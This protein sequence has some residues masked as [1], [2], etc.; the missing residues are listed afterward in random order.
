MTRIIVRINLS[1]GCYY[2]CSSNISILFL[3]YQS[4]KIKYVY[5]NAIF[6]FSSKK[7]ALCCACFYFMNYLNQTKV[8]ISIVIIKIITVSWQ[9]IQRHL[10]NSTNSKCGTFPG[11]TG[12]TTGLGQQSPRC[13]VGVFLCTK[14]RDPI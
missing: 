12:M 13:L 1:Q 6:Y 4:F 14:L 8:I 3:S 9:L 7:L 5:S 11:G 2:Y 10:Y